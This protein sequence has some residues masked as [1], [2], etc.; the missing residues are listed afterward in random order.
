M[1]FEIIFFL[2]VSHTLKKRLTSIIVCVYLQSFLYSFQIYK[3]MYF[4]KE[5]INEKKN[6]NGV[7]CTLL[8][9]LIVW[10]R[11]C[12]I[13]TLMLILLLTF[14][15]VLIFIHNNSVLFHC[16]SAYMCIFHYV[17]TYTLTVP[18]MS[19]TIVSFVY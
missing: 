10:W 4:K 18:C 13:F 3:N 14:Y 7:A 1:A 15:R 8:L 11:S 12:I 17:F 9:G 5:K 16:F 6:N 2:C 19:C